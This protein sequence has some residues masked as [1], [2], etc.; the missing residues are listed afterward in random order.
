M[1]IMKSSKLVQKINEKLN[2]LSNKKS[3]QL[4]NK[5]LYIFS[6]HDMKIYSGYATLYILMAIPPL[7]MLII[8]IVNR[9]PSL[10]AQDFSEQFMKF[11]PELPQVQALLD[12]VIVNLNNQSSDLVLS[13][14]AITTLW[15]ASLGVTAMQEGLNHI[16][17]SNRPS[18]YG[19]PLAILFTILFVLLIPSLLVFQLLRNPIVNVVGSILNFLKIPNGAEWFKS[20]METSSIIS[21]I[22]LIIAI[23]M[24]YTYLPYGKRSIKSQIPGAVIG[25]VIAAVFTWGFSLFMGT[26]WS[27]SAIYGSLAAIFLSALWLKTAMS[28]FFLG[29]CY[30][31]ARES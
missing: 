17:E 19:K 28:I 9:I 14:S 26:F 11:I 18:V 4:L 30:N 13:F 25:F 16:N 27:N 20:F 5:T 31:K 7:L 15:S 24:T 12:D 22:V 21:V 23:L 2:K 1:F 8:N 29:A 3:V 6:T 10:T